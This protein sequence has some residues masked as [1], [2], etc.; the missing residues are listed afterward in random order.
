VL[1]AASAAYN[2]FVQQTYSSREAAELF[3]GEVNPTTIQRAIT[4][5]EL[6]ATKGPHAQSRF[7]VAHAD[8]MAWAGTRGLSVVN[9]N[10]EHVD[11]ATGEVL[12]PEAIADHAVK[13]A[14]QLKQNGAAAPTESNV[15]AALLPAA[16]VYADR[17]ALIIRLVRDGHV[18][19]AQLV[20][21]AWEA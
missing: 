14:A 6:P 5:G 12:E 11:A 17:L 21:A 1:Q 9:G 15:V 3:G 20:I 4:R 10:G 8:L 16:N 2:A 7:R 19:A 13:P 18:D